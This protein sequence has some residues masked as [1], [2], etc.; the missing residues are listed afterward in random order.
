MLMLLDVNLSQRLAFSKDFPQQ[1][2]ANYLFSHCAEWSSFLNSPEEKLNSH[3][4]FG[5]V[6]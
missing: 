6:L 2:F 3:V 4:F 1:K 5:E